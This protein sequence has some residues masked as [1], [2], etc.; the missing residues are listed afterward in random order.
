MA[1]IKRMRYFDQQLLVLKDF[2]DEQ[3]YHREMRRRHNQALHTTGVASGLD[4]TK[5]GA[6]EV[7]VKAGMAI[8][9]Q[10]Q[11]IVL[12]VDTKIDLSNATLFPPNSSALVT[13]SFDSTPTDPYASDTTQNT[14]IKETFRLAATKETA[15]TPPDPTA[16]QLARVTLDALGNITLDLSV[17]RLA[18]AS[19]FDKPDAALTVRSLRLSNQAF[20]NTQWPTLTATDANQMTV[21]GALVAGSVSVTG[22]INVN[23]G[24]KA[25]ADLSGRNLSLTGNLGVGTTTPEDKLHVSGGNMRLDNN[26]GLFIEDAAG[27]G[28]RALS[29]D[30]SNVLHIGGGGGG[31]FDRIDFDLGSTGTAMTLSGGHAGIGTVTPENSDGF[32][33]VVDILGVQHTKLSIRSNT[34]DARVIAHE[35][36]F[37]GAP[38]G[39]VIGAKSNHPLSFATNSASRLTILGD[40]RIG[41]GTANPGAKLEIN[42]GDLL[43]KAKAEDPGKIIFQ[44]SAGGQKGRIWSNSTAG[45]GLFLSSGDNNPDIT[46]DS[47]GRVGIGATAPFTDLTVTGSLGFANAATPMMFIFQSGTSNP[48]RGIAVHSPPFPDWGLY[49]NDNLDQMIFRFGGSPA[50]TISTGTVRVDGSLT[51]TGAKSGYVVDQFMNKYEEDLEEGDVVVISDNS[52]PLHYGL[53]YKIPVPEVD[54][55]QQAYDTKVCGIVSEIHVEMKSSVKAEPAAAARKTKN[56]APVQGGMIRKIGKKIEKVEPQTFTSDQLEHLDRTKIGPGQIGLMVTLGAFA[57]CKVDADVAPI[58]V[59]DLLT[60]SPTRGHAQKALDPAKAVGAII[61]KALGS[62]KKG[63]GKIPVLVMLQ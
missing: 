6:K 36:G 28:K 32:S 20:P 56:V 38:A 42:D 62:L 3:D 53:D 14:R 39:M 47:S 52:A 35:S 57:H 34:I 18:G 30:P 8:D 40:G 43:F 48:E 60:T 11:E 63:K 1:D 5:T 58:N 61:G 12:D 51:V 41:I 4:V 29:A 55:T 7:T 59:G 17:R 24:V 45:A 54:V 49:Y 27:A 22:D 2:T 50:L 46:I 10:G 15:G 33:R 31:G 21:S 37:W 25:L 44:S 26:R 9:N 16:V 19:A 13:I 23:G